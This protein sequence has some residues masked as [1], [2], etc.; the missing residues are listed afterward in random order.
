MVCHYWVFKHGSQ[1]QDSF[2]NGF[3]DVTVLSLDIKEIAI[4][5]VKSVDHCCNFDDITKFDDIHFLENF[6][7]GDRGY[8]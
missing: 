1:F 5:I 8:I 7:L 4:I 2:C 6:V 3:H